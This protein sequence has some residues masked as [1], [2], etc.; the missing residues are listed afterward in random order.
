MFTNNIVAITGKMA[1]P[2][3]SIVSFIESEGGNNFI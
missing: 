1:I 3:Q 2:R